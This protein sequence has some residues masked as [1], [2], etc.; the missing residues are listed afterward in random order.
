VDSNGQCA[1]GFEPRDQNITGLC[2]PDPL[3]SPGENQIAPFEA[4]NL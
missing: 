4:E 1:N 2:F 3:G